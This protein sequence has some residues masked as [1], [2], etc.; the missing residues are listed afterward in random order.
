MGKRKKTGKRIFL[1]FCI[2]TLSIIGAI[3]YYKN[4][5]KHPFK[6][7]DESFKIMV[8]EGSGIYTVLNTM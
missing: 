6:V 1:I 5:I 3:T 2:V 4:V 7:K 8:E